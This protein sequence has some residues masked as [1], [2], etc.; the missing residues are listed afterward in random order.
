MSR[1]FVRYYFARISSILSLLSLILFNYKLS[2]LFLLSSRA[3]C[4]VRKCLAIVL[5]MVAGESCSTIFNDRC[6][7]SGTEIC[8]DVVLYVKT[9]CIGSL[10]IIPNG[11]CCNFEG[12]VSFLL[13]NGRQ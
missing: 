12:S 8:V 4:V 10:E 9:I 5:N 13:Y 1:C 2:S 3:G 11:S 7:V 6:N